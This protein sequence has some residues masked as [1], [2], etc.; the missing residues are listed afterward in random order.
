MNNHYILANDK[1]GKVFYYPKCC[2][3]RKILY[4]IKIPKIPT[5]F[6]NRFRIYYCDD[7]YN[8]IFRL[9]ANIPTNPDASPNTDWGP[10]F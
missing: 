1:N 3:C 8:Q 5:L 10:I 7:C 9:T 6:G 4:E 2:S